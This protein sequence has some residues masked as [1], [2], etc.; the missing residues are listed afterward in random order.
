MVDGCPN[1]ISNSIRQYNRDGMHRLDARQL[2]AWVF[3][4]AKWLGMRLPQEWT[5]AGY[6]T[7][8]QHVDVGTK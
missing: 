4:S 3:W 6:N 8:W 2:P 5:Y 1:P 7:D